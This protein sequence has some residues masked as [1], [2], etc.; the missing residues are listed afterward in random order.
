MRI[1]LAMATLSMVLISIF[2]SHQAVEALS[3][4]AEVAAIKDMYDKRSA[5]MQA[6]GADGY[7]EVSAND[8]V[9]MPPSAPAIVGR[10]AIRRWAQNFFSRYTI[11]FSITSEE[12]KV[13][14][15]VAIR[16]F[17]AVGTYTPV[18][19]GDTIEFD[20]K[21]LDILQKQKDGSWQISY[22]VWSSNNDLPGI[23]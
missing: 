9:L 15:N 11:K 6:R 21:Y 2:G 14:G 7:A 10:N 19:G 16:H 18:A 1:S 4:Q 20:Q 12:I 3:D 8:A 5:R 13:S 17:T 23:W 22:H